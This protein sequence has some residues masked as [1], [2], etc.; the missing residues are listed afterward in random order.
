MNRGTDV[1]DQKRKYRTAV[2]NEFPDKLSFSLDRD[3]NLSLRYGEN[4]HQPAALYRLDQNNLAEY[5]NLRLAKGGKGGI[6]TI[7]LMDVARAL[8]ILKYFSK[9]SV[10]VMKHT[11]PSGF[12]TQSN[13]EGLGDIYIKARDADR[14]SAFGSTVVLNRMMDRSTAEAVTSTYVEVVAAPGYE[15]NVMELLERK[16][17]LRVMLFSDL[18]TIPK[19]TGDDTDEGYDIRTLPTGHVLMQTPYLSSIRAKNDLILDPMVIKDEKNY[20]VN[21]DP[22][23]RELNDLLVAWYVNLGVRSNG[24]VFVRDGVTIAIGSGQQERVGAVEQAIIKA[25]QKS[26]DRENISYDPID[27]AVGR[28]AL[29][30]NPL[31]GAVVSSDAFF[32]FRDS[33][34]LIAKH[35]VSA[36]IQPGG[37]RNDYEVIE[38]VNEHNLAMAFTLER[39]F[40]HF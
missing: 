37:S 21:R 13:E 25:Y 22:T 14:R 23:D 27:G 15:E 17:D 12:S 9:P 16:K 29:Y 31:E 3:P 10:A 40:G 38:A 2:G 33:I 26:M 34:D 39:C 30:Y 20:V 1:T 32:P 24:I 18:E 6:S 7:N 36:V 19:F 35:G 11:I 5:I 4:P 8:N 28:D